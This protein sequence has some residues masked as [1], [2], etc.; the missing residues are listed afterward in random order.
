MGYIGASFSTREPR[1]SVI[2][3]SFGQIA[4]FISAARKLW[5]IVTADGGRPAAYT[6]KRSS[7]VNHSKALNIFFSP[8]LAKRFYGTHAENMST[9][10]RHQGRRGLLE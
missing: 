9:K 3:V 6:A 10:T 7:P 8:I 1:S 5:S 4:E 2:G